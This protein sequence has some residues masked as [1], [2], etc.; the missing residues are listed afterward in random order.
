MNII[1]ATASQLAQ[2][3]RDKEISA[4]EVLDAYLEQIAKHNDKINAIATL[5]AERAKTR[6]KEA[7]EALARD[8]NWGLLHGVP[9]TI[10]DTFETAGLLTTAGYKPLKNYISQ[11]DATV[12]ARLKAAGAIIARLGSRPLIVGGDRSLAVVQDR[13]QPVLEQQ[14]LQF[15]QASYGTD[16]SEAI[17]AVFMALCLQ[18]AEFLL[19]DIFPNYQETRSTFAIYLG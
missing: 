1:F 16:C 12:A 11:Q 19:Q 3:I 8:E 7:D 15:T 14:K 6:A 2:M 18:I 10:K 9:I 4:V 17:A 5:D 13:L